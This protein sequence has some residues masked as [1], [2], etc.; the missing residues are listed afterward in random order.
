MKTLGID[1]VREE[2]STTYQAIVDLTGP[3]CSGT[4]LEGQPRCKPM[5]QNRCCDKWHCDLA[6][7]CIKERG[8]EVPEPTG[9]PELP[10]MGKEGCILEPWLR[11]ACSLHVCAIHSLGLFMESPEMTKQYFEL[12]EKINGLEWK[13]RKL[14]DKEDITEWHDYSGP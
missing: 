7:N 8:L 3:V 10:F 2:L 5:S 4:L 11:P 14:T 9:H 13:Y 6:A 1:S 12:R